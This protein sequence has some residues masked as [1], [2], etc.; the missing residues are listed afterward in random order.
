MTHPRNGSRSRFTLLL[1]A[2]LGGL[3]VAGPADAKKKRSKKA[4][5]SI[6]MTGVKSF[7]K[8]FREAKT[9]NKKLRAAEADLKSSRKA[10]RSALGLSKKSTYVQGLNELKRRADGKLRLYLNNGRPTLKATDAVPSGVQDGIDAINELTRTIPS[11][12]RNLKGVATSSTKMFKKAK[13]F[14]SNL[15]TE[16]GSQGIDGLLDLLFKAPRITRKTVRN[17]KVIGGMPKRAGKTSKEL[18]LIS[19]TVKDI[20]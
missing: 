3:M 16:L 14:P 1:V 9:A 11:S 20:F 18:A 7:D 13:R 15:R 17:V 8:V 4:N 5:T 19:T 2:V 6:T 12:I 10:L